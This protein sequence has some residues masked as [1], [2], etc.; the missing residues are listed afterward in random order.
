MMH[1]KTTAR[2]M[3]VG[4]FAVVYGCLIC[5]EALGQEKRFDGVTLRVATY[6]GPWKDALQELIG[7]DME[8][9]GAKIE[10]ETGSPNQH[11]AK[12]IIARGKAVPFDVT[13]IDDPTAPQF[14][15]AGVL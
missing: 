9:R 6:G 4:F 13:E 15:E 5:S 14:V 7:A 10:W 8:K 11:L 2:V 1:A 12:L 3:L